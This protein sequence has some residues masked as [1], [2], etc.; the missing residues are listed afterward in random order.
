MGQY[1]KNRLAEEIKKE[2]SDIIRTMKDPRLGLLSIIKVEVDADLSNAK[3][4]I[5]H[6]GMAE[7]KDETM[8]ALQRGSG[9]IR[10]EL[11]KRLQTR[12]VPELVFVEDHSIEQGFRISQILADYEKQNPSRPKEDR[13]DT[14]E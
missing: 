13:E 7:E 3:I 12:T 2:L 6:F 9:Y 4:Y 10:R 1:R 11:A 8:A 14:E 5:S